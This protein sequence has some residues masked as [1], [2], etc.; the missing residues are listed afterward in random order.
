MGDVEKGKKIF[1]H[2]CAQCHTVEKAGKHKTGPNL[3]GMF[4]CKMV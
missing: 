3:P 4:V 1:V 2:K